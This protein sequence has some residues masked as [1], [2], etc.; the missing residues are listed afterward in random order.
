MKYIDLIEYP[1]IGEVVFPDEPDIVY[2]NRYV[3]PRWRHNRIHLFG[4]VQSSNSIA[5]PSE[6]QSDQPSLHKSPELR[7]VSF[8]G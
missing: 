1:T 8:L 4:I 7:L 3:L 6:S 5:C 2:V